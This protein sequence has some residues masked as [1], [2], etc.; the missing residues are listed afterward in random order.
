MKKIVVQTNFWLPVTYAILPLW[1]FFFFQMIQ[2]LFLLQPKIDND[3][4]ES[5]SME[6]PRIIVNPKPSL[7]GHKGIDI[8][9]SALPG[10]PLDDFVVEDIDPKTWVVPGS[11]VRTTQS[12]FISNEL[13]IAERFRLA[14]VERDARMAPKRAKNARQRQRRAAREWLTTSTSAKSIVLATQMSKNLHI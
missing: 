9:K 5:L 13:S 14:F 8:P 10:I 6:C 11:R 3:S 7:F 12:V 1:L 4:L 2:E